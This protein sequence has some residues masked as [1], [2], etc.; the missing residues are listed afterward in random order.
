MGIGNI[1][2][3]EIFRQLVTIRNMD[4]LY[5]NVCTYLLYL[6]FN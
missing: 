1:S 6:S 3:I 2:N 5:I 4:I